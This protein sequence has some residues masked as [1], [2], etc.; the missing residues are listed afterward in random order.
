MSRDSLI[1]DLKPLAAHF[2]DIMAYNTSITIS[3][4]INVE[5][6]IYLDPSI[7]ERTVNHENFKVLRTLINP[8]SVD[9]FQ[10]TI[11]AFIHMCSD[12]LSPEFFRVLLEGVILQPR[13]IAARLNTR[14]HNP[15]KMLQEAREG[16]LELLV[17]SGGKDK[18]LNV[19]GFKAV[20][21]DLG[22]KKHTY[23]H[24]EEADHIPWV[25]CPEGFREI[26][27]SWISERR[28]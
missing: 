19:E 7:T 4:L 15:E 1:K 11:L 20:F 5:G 14:K 6:A 10:E 25:S 22:W 3:G 26:V 12:K 16:R 17:V 8:P 23:K 2:V 9:V 24:L 18:L 21:E 28:Y 27:L 13:T